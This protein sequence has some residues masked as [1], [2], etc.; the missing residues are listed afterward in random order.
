M[1]YVVIS[2]V[3]FPGVYLRMDGT[4]VTAHLGSGGGKVNCQ[5]GASAWETFQI[6]W[7][8]GGINVASVQFPGVCLRMDGAGVTASAPSGGTVNCQYDPAG[9][10]KFTLE[11]QPDGT[12]AIAS[13]QF[14]GVYLH[15]DGT[16]VTAPT[17]SGGGTVNCQYGVGA[18]ATF[19]F[20]GVPAQ[21][22]ELVSVPSLVGMDQQQAFQA[23]S[24][25]GLTLQY[26]TMEASVCPRPGTIRLQTPLAGTEV[27]QGSTVAATACVPFTPPPSPPHG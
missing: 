8:L 9:W 1:A 7:V 2:S 14:P 17:A 27:Q 12:V 16:G 25:A 26:S 5:Y 21:L 6:Q 13:V 24:A 15:M 18:S 23:L 4:G 22:P 20:T 10:E 19:R 11:W 3:Q